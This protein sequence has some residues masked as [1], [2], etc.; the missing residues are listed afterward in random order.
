MNVAARIWRADVIPS[1]INLQ[2]KMQGSP[3]DQISKDALESGIDS[4]LIARLPKLDKALN[5]LPYEPQLVEPLL[6]DIG[7]LIDRCVSYQ[8]EASELEINW[9]RHLW[10]NQLAEFLNAEDQSGSDF[11]LATETL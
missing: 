6:S 10:D 5:P 1:A 7:A 4:T 11:D 3:I 9:V 8:R 2:E